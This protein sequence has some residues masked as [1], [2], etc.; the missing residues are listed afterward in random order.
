[1]NIKQVPAA[2]GNYSP[3]VS[4]KKFFVMH[5]IVGEQPVADKIFTTPNTKVSAHFSVASNG[6][7]HQYVP[8]EQRAFHAGVLQV[9]RDAIGIE[10]AGGQLIHGI[11]KKPTQECHDASAELIA[12]L[13]TTY[14]IPVI[15]EPHSK[16]VATQCCGSLDIKYIEK[17]AKELMKYPETVTTKDREVNL[18]S[19][20]DRASEIVLKWKTSEQLLVQG[21]RIGNFY[22]VKWWCGAF[23]AQGSKIK[24]SG[25]IHTNDILPIKK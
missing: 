19:S 11:R 15:L 24:Y 25:Y 13:A 10:H 14:D 6:E 4:K 7:I 20:Y 8:V 1:M 18:Y 5:W 16:F 2:Q 17:K 9:N 21:P 22:P 3:L 12:Y 23:D